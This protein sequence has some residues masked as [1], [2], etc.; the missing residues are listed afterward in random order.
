[1][2]INDLFEKTQS[3]KFDDN[4][5]KSLTDVLVMFKTKNIET[6]HINNIINELSTMGFSVSK[7]DLINEIENMDGFEIDENEYV[8]VI[9]ENEIN[10]DTE[11]IGEPMDSE[12]TEEGGYDRVAN[13]AKDAVDD[14]LQ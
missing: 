9:D 14:N 13:I 1:M 7:D 8:N 6:T 12:G 4:L 5:H 11:T 2:R 3:E 10:N